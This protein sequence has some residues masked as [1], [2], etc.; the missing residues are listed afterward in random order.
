MKRSGKVFLAVFIVCC[1]LLPSIIINSPQS[2]PGELF[3]PVLKWRGNFPDDEGVIRSRLVTINFQRLPGLERAE[4]KYLEAPYPFLL[5][6]FADVKLLARI[7]NVEKISPNNYYCELD[8][9]AAPDRESRGSFIIKKGTFSAYII[10]SGHFYLVRPVSEGI[11][12]IEEVTQS[13]FPS[14]ISSN[15]SGIKI[16]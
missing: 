11:Y 9:E 15:Y 8:I 16:S 14:K 10:V 3:S 12:K 4:V 6:L 5:N 7:R 13:R 2:T 1:L